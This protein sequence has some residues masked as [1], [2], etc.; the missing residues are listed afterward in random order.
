MRVVAPLLMLPFVTMSGSTI[1]NGAPVGAT[2]L[3]CPSATFCSDTVSGKGPTVL[4]PRERVVSAVSP[5][6]T[7]AGRLIKPLPGRLMEVSAVS[8]SKTPT[9]RLLKPLWLR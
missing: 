3:N 8:P 4:W 1:S 5:S 2:A 7:P 6:K 9:D